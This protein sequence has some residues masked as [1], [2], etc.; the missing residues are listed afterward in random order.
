MYLGMQYHFENMEMQ[1]NVIESVSHP[2]MI[3]TR[4][5]SRTLSEIYVEAFLRK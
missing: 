5:V 1:T 3:E 4:R 2:L